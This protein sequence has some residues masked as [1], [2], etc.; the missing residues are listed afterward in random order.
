MWYYSE[1]T[2]L[3]LTGSKEFFE[4]PVVNVLVFLE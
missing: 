2:S 4:V 1:F 3:Q